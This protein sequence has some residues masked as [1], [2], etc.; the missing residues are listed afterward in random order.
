MPPKKKQRPILAVNRS[1]RLQ[2]RLADIQALFQFLDEIRP[3]AVAAGELS[4]VFMDEGEHMDLHH[5]FMYDE[6]PTDVI[7]FQGDPGMDFA[8]EICVSVDFAASSAHKRNLPFAQELT[9]YLIHGWLHL[10]GFN[11]KTELDRKKMRKEETRLL[12]EIEAAELQPRF[13]I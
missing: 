10:A 9:L 7:T 4:I 1:E 5:K 6:T 11:D 8:G 3:H 13:Q 2:I 12:S